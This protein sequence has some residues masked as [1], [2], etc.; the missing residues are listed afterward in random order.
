M[1]LRDITFR[2]ILEGYKF[3]QKALD[4]TIPNGGKVKLY[5]CGEHAGEYLE[6]R[7]D[8]GVLNG[9]A[10]IK[11]A[12]Y[13]VLFE[14]H[15]V[16]GKITGEYKQL[17]N[18]HVRREGTLVDCKRQGYGS[19]YDDMGYLIYEGEYDD[20]KPTDSDFDFPT[21]EDV[22][23]KCNYKETRGTIIR[24]RVDYPCYELEVD[25]ENRPIRFRYVD[26]DRSLLL[27]LYLSNNMM[28]DYANG[29]VYKGDFMHD[30]LKEFRRKGMSDRDYEDSLK[31]VPIIPEKEIESVSVSMK[32][33]EGDLVQSVQALVRSLQNASDTD[34]DSDL[35]MEAP[36]PRR[37]RAPEKSVEVKPI[38]VKP[39]VVTPVEEVKPVAVKPAMVTPVVS[40]VVSPVNPEEEKIMV[41]VE[42]MKRLE[43]QSRENKDW[44]ELTDNNN[45]DYAIRFD[46]GNEGDTAGMCAI[47]Y[48]G[49][50]M[51]IGTTKG[52]K[53]HGRVV[54]FDDD[55]NVRYQREYEN[56]I[57]K[58]RWLI[59][60]NKITAVKEY[61][62]RETS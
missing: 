52:G 22:K 2:G 30:P 29:D 36:F 47:Y 5:F 34:S 46:P 7:A 60:D 32:S 23:Y 14:L 16:N 11:N 40:P 35:S 3:S 15:I 58:R 61:D 17:A 21:K 45:K 20:D 9:K 49:K 43:E 28:L 1:A 37:N 41:N 8:N 4:T 18:G 48:K 24:K 51:R 44:K 56:G 54:D 6:A 59:K 26:G 38:E 42:I 12:R 31:Q 13:Q 62:N 53:L 19:E 33:S 57:E 10:A 55:G 50:C 39:V 27:R 25:L